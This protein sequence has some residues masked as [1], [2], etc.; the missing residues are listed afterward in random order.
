MTGAKSEG[1]SL[2]A[3]LDVALTVGQASWARCRH[4]PAE[5]AAASL[6]EALQS[7]LDSG[8]LHAALAS[9][10]VAAV[11]GWAEAGGTAGVAVDD[12]RVE[13]RP[14]DP[15]ASMRWKQVVGEVVTGVILDDADATVSRLL[16]VDVMQTRGSDTDTDRFNR[17]AGEL[18]RLDGAEAWFVAAAALLR[19]ADVCN[20]LPATPP[21]PADLPS[22]ASDADGDRTG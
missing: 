17:L 8:A 15:R 4:V 5:H 7:V 9:V 6:D 16:L 13:D 18:L 10:V 2:R 14:D 12:V 11:P 1:A 21:P 3:V 22:A 19:L 20:E